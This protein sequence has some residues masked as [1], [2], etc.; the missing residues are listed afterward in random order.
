MIRLINLVDSFQLHQRWDKLNFM[1]ESCSMFLAEIMNFYPLLHGCSTTSVEVDSG[2]K[3]TLWI[4]R[5]LFRIWKIFL[6]FGR[7]L[8]FL[9]GEFTI[10][11]WSKS[12]PAIDSFLINDI[13]NLLLL[14]FK[15][16]GKRFN[17][18][19]F[20][21]TTKTNMKIRLTITKQL[22]GQND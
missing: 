13:L 14:N 12:A 20:R 6:D 18:K 11:T 7:Y 4:S 21:K 15:S 5:F 10:F 16:S 2:V 3:K 17:L 8:K 19:V 22:V 9:P 1:E